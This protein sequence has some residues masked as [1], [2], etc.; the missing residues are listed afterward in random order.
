VAFSAAG[1]ISHRLS[2]EPMLPQLVYTGEAAPN[3]M[4][5]TNCSTLSVGAPPLRIISC[6]H[7][8]NNALLAVAVKYTMNCR[9]GRS[10]PTSPPNP[11][12]Y[13]WLPQPAKRECRVPRVRLPGWLWF[14]KRWWLRKKVGGTPDTAVSPGSP[15]WKSVHHS[16]TPTCVS[17]VA[18]AAST[19]LCSACAYVR[20]LMS[21]AHVAL[22]DGSM[23]K[24]VAMAGYCAS[25]GATPSAS[26]KFSPMGIPKSWMNASMP[27]TLGYATPS[28]V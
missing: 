1:S 7:Q 15:C 28:H 13:R 18:S 19:M 23:P 5:R 14:M 2:S 17:L 11:L 26:C 22:L 3:C 21:N 27:V 20:L 25:K 9:D 4:K 24:A 10:S 8:P 12:A 6:P 16:S